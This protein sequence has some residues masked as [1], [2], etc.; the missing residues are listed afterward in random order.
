VFFPTSSPAFVV[1]VIDGGL[2][3]WDEVDLSAVLICVSFMA[4]DAGHFF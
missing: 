4:K 3:D 1:C 2:S